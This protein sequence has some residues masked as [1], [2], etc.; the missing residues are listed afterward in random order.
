MDEAFS[1]LDPLIRREMQEELRQLQQRLRKTIVFVSHDLDEAI[2]LGG[3]IVLMKDGQI[4]QIGWPEEILMNPAT[5]YVRRFVEHI[6]VSSVLTVGRIADASAPFVRPQMSVAEA[7]AAVAGHPARACY[8]IEPS[9][10][11]AGRVGAGALAA[12][13][14]PGRAVSEIMQAEI[15]CVPASSTLKAALPVLTSHRDGVAVVDDEHR[16]VGTLTSQGVVAALARS[17]RTDASTDLSAG[18]PRTRV[19]AAESAS[20]PGAEIPARH[21]Q[22]RQHGLVDPEVSAG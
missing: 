8:A 10:R 22:E 13:A 2:N 11:L 12:C 14:D 16:F 21:M 6:D 19:G 20:A 15:A 3:R 18:D 4:V 5:E 17:P 7:R 1:A 9:G